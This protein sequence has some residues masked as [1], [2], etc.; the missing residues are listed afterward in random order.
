M[1]FNYIWQIEDVQTV[2]WDVLAQIFGTDVDFAGSEVSMDA[3][4][5][6]NE[7]KR[8]MNK[9]SQTE[10]KENFTVPIIETSKQ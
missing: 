8:E 9:A 4:V 2:D 5:S 3:C 1:I 6:Q 10:E 7:A